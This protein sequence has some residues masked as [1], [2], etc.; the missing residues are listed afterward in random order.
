MVSIRRV[1]GLFVDLCGMISTGR[2][3]NASGTFF[4]FIFALLFMKYVKTSRYLTEM[5]AKK[6]SARGTL[7]VL[8]LE[9]VMADP[10]IFILCVAEI[11]MTGH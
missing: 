2:S 5:R 11:Y 1:S 6:S 9:C 7:A 10:M 8:I 4:E 3:F